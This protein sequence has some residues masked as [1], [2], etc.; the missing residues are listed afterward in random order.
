MLERRHVLGWT[1]GVL[2]LD[3]SANLISFGTRLLDV[4]APYATV[5]WSAS[6][7]REQVLSS[8]NPNDHVTIV[9]G[10]TGE[11]AHAMN[12]PFKKRPV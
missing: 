1:A 9:H 10:I 6:R 12:D 4:A 3:T 2:L 7:Y 8:H 5:F 11:Y